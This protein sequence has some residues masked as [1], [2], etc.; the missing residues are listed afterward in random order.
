MDY[1]DQ[2]LQNVVFAPL[3]NHIPACSKT[4]HCPDFSDEQFLVTCLLRTFSHDESGRDFLQNLIELHGV[5]NVER[6]QFFETLKSTRRLGFLRE[7]S[8]LLK[9]AS[10]S[11]LGANDAFASIPEL[12]GREIYAGDGHYIEHACHDPR[13]PAYKNN[14]YVAIGHFYAMNLRTYWLDYMDLAL[15]GTK[16][17]HD[18]KVLKRVSEQLKVGGKKG[19]IWIWDKAGIDGQFW[20]NQ[21]QAH[22][23]YFISRL[24]ENMKP[25][26]CGDRQWDK[27][28]ERND[29]I[30]EDELVGISGG[31]M[32]RVVTYVDPETGKEWKYLTSD[33][34]LP[35]GIIAH[36][37]R[38][39]WTI[40][41]T[42]DETENRLH[43]SKGWGTN[44]TAKRM[45][46]HFTA[47]A[48]NLM[49]LLETKAKQEEGIEDKKVE[50][51]FA[52]ALDK[53]EEE[54]SR[55][56]RRVPTM[57]RQLRRRATQISF[58]FIRWLRNH[59]A[60]RASYRAS[61]PAL[62]RAM[63]VYL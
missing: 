4:R 56:G 41:K 54:A 25:T 46:A 12:D 55:Q 38:V 59:L 11:K 34:T 7:I 1:P 28:D 2:S 51:K 42:F 17:Q 13:N 15:E 36:L 63:E 3:V 19:A 6:S 57:I 53:R 39:R 60:I 16:K 44:E 52:K 21:K 9:Q 40:E 35:P 61:L 10:E 30:T 14:P 49:L 23:V 24:K 62:R 58:Q 50:E 45:Q 22:G 47:L 33:L 26:K 18:M 32:M 5:T 48:H 37:Y 27:E 8:A 20:H 31:Y 29:G 43:Q